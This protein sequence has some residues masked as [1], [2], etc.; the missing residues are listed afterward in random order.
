[1][2][3]LDIDHDAGN[4]SEEVNESEEEEETTETEYDSKNS[5][6]EQFIQHKNISDTASISGMSK[7][8]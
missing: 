2:E 7:N 5:D 6:D 1:M 3:K 4:E 8:Y